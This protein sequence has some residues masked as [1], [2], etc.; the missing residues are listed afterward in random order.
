MK[1]GSTRNFK[2]KKTDSDLNRVR[3]MLKTSKVDY[4]DLMWPDPDEIVLTIQ[5]GGKQG[6]IV[7]MYFG[8]DGQFRNIGIYED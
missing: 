8:L 4:T 1:T 7:E 5:A 3:S 2:T 6:H